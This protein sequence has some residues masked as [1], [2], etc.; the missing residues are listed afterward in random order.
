MKRKENHAAELII[1]NKN[2]FKMTRKKNERQIDVL[3][4]NFFSK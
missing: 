3:I 4:K 1:A 2:S